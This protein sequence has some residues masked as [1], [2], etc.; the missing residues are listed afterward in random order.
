M[1]KASNPLLDKLG[2]S[3][4]DVRR[5]LETCPVDFSDTEK[6]VLTMRRGLGDGVQHTLQYGADCYTAKG[7]HICAVTA[8]GGY[9]HIR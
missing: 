7:R 5:V 9:R 1:R 6:Q 4:N 2:L 8:C 3:V